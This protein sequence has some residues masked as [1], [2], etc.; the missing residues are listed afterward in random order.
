MGR[1]TANDLR[2]RRAKLN[3]YRYDNYAIG[4]IAADGLY[5]DQLLKQREYDY[6][7]MLQLMK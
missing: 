5:Q 4:Q 2:R 7:L 3:R 1:R 6:Q